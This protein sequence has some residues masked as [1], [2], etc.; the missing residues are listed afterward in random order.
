MA[1]VSEKF[2]RTVRLTDVTLRV[3][4]LAAQRA[5]YTET[6]GLRV[7]AGDGA[8][9]CLG[10]AAGGPAL[11]VL[12]P[13]PAAPPRP[14]GAAGLFHAALLWPDRASLGRMVQRLLARR[15]PFGTG[16]HGV[17]EAIYLDDP[18]G[19]GLELYADRPRVQW[20]PDGPDGQVTMY[21]RAVD[22]PGLLAD[23]AQTAGPFLP[24]DTQVGHVHLGVSSLPRAEEFYGGRLG[25]AVRQ[26]SVPGALFLGRDGYHH[27]FGA[28]TWETNRPAV[29]GAR[30]LVRFTI[31]FS[32]AAELAR[33]AAG[34]T[35]P[36][37]GGANV[38]RDADGIE[39]VL[40]GPAAAR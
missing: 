4:D 20:P 18:E 15:V 34:A 7:L 21:T 38:L 3:R 19:N 33:V 12:E 17:S 6:L 31:R 30:G 14:A 9:C 27:H 36:G 24:E 23:A 13:A 40:A 25:F 39:V 8:Q 16:D 10:A 26:R 5:F 1:G 22:V 11:L 29:P 37:A 32:D 35:G 2:F 28:N